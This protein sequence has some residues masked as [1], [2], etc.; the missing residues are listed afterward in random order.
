MKAKIILIGLGLLGLVSCGVKTPSEQKGEPF[1]INIACA[2]F[3]NNFPGEC[4]KDY[5]YPTMEDLK[6]WQ[7][8]GLNLIRMP[9]KWERLQH[10]PGGE[11]H[12][13]D[14]Q[15]VKDFVTAAEQ[16]DMKVI[17]DMHNYCRR[18]HNGKVQIIGQD[19]ITNEHYAE[20]WKK[21]ADEF[22]NYTN[23]YGYGLM[24][25]PYDLDEDIFWISMAQSAIDS[26]RVSDPNTTII[27]GGNHWSSASK[28]KHVS[29]TLKYL[30][31]PSDKLLYEAHCYFDK[32]NSGTYKYSYE[33]EEGT[34]DKGV[35][36]VTPFV[37]W[38]K[39]NGLKGFIGEYGIPV[40]DPDWEI[41]LDNFLSY[42]STN[43]I[44]GTYWASGSWWPDDAVMVI[45][46]YKGGAERSQVK[47][48]EKY[49]EANIIR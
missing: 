32:D 6:Y 29:D 28:W 42:L 15:A 39:E 26:I 25:E 11:L 37:E 35:E 36:L 44:N 48:L 27:V 3:G 14:L 5:G 1:G 38:L 18:Y 13:P 22:K 20:F 33:E 16:L 47:I 4:G 17:L 23:I 9:F 46:T 49:K 21:M 34:P 41:T 10:E 12:S 19:D 40:N 2:E 7:E 43:G 31:D 45:P 24:N 8:K 30:K